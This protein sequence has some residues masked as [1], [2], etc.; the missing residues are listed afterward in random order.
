MTDHESGILFEFGGTL[1]PSF[2]R[3]YLKYD[4]GNIQEAIIRD[5]QPVIIDAGNI[6]FK[7]AKDIEMMN[8]KRHEELKALKQ[9]FSQVAAQIEEIENEL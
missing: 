7:H 1:I 8:Q 9:L 6:M 4:D 5:E 2:K 3:V